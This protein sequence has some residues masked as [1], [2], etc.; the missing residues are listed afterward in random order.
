MGLRHCIDDATNSETP[1]NKEYIKCLGIYDNQN[2]SL[3]SI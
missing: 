1:I 2:L 3:D